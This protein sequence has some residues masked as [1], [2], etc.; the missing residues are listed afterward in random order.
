MT[1]GL[2]VKDLNAHNILKDFKSIQ[3]KE[4]EMRANFKLKN[5]YSLKKKAYKMNSPE[6]QTMGKGSRTGS[7][8]YEV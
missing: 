6:T 4:K 8:E 2:M 3:D 5:L 7:R 1:Q